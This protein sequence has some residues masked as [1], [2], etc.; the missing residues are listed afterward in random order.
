[1]SLE[2]F[3]ELLDAYGAESA[4]WPVEEREA[5]LLLAAGSEEAR[6]L[7]KEAK[8]LDSL[9]D[10]SV[11]PKP[12]AELIARVMS[13]IPSRRA[14]SARRWGI[15][16]ARALWS[17]RGSYAAAGAAC[18]LAALILL[19]LWM[20]RSSEPPEPALT[21]PQVALLGTYTMPTDVLLEPSV[22]DLLDTLPAFGCEGSELA[23]PDL[24]G[25]LE[26]QSKLPL[27][28]RTLG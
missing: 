26:P 4:R 22:V 17:M 9:L 13:G 24:E 12:S 1:M 7:R 3:R 28:R 25:G 6:R 21:Q 16:F 2:R 15:G 23:C 19:I 5:A 11:S 27:R 20:G 8:R 10:R 18:G 14:S